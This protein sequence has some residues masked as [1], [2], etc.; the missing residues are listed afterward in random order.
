MKRPL[1][2]IF[3]LIGALFFLFEAIIHFFGLPVLEHNKIFLPTHD[4]YI[5]LFA[6]TYAL[7][8]VLVS[9]DLEKYKTPFLITMIGILLA[10]LN[11][12][13]ISWSGG[14][15][16]FFPVDRLDVNLSFLGVG[17]YTWYALT[18]I[19]YLRGK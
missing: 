1:F 13:W 9:T 2:R 14:Y 3:L 8:L 15:K 5:A 4:R 7:L 6:L 12:T 19:S 10:I 11:A 16:L 17:V 18:W